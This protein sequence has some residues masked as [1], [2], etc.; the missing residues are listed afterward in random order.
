MMLSV[1]DEAGH[2]SG[3][4]RI[5]IPPLVSANTCDTAPFSVNRMLENPFF[6]FVTVDL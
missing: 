5:S 3:R 2:R 4:D 1:E 6:H